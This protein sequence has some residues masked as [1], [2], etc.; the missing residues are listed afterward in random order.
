MDA[1][2]EDIGAGVLGCSKCPSF[3]DCTKKIIGI[4]SNKAS[5]VVVGES[6]SNGDLVS[7]EAFSGKSGQYLKRLLHKAG[8]RKG[9]LYLTYA[10]KCKCRSEFSAKEAQ[11]DCSLH[12]LKQI[13]FIRPKL[14]IALG[15]VAFDVLCPNVKRELGGCRGDKIPSFGYTVMPVWH[16]GFVLS[17]FSELRAKEIEK[18]ICRAY[19]Y[20]FFGTD[21][22]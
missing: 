14:I 1:S 13:D 2:W 12:L 7:G 3:C 21:D 20:T 10:I 15:A 9:E 19:R 5:A 17:S 18:D 6:P 8:Y 16:P 22:K 11:G 4:G